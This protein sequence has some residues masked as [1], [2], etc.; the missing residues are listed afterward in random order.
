MWALHALALIADSGGPMFRN[1]VEPTLS[2]MLNLLVATPPQAVEVH[3]CLAKCLSALITTLGP[4]LQDT[5]A[6]M[7]ATRKT[8]LTCC[9]IVQDHPDAVV[10]SAA[11]GA[12]FNYRL[13][14]DCYCIT[15]Y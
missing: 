7:R 13:I 4:E 6:S 10:Q 15:G 2:L 14:D 8:C 11:I 5:S 3:Q 9:S 1:Y 12:D